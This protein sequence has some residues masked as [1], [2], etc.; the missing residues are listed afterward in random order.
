MHVGT[1]PCTPGSSAREAGTAQLAGE[2]ALGMLCCAVEKAQQ[3]GHQYLSGT[4][5]NVAKALTHAQP[6]LGAHEALS[7]AGYGSS[8]LPRAAS[9]PAGDCPRAYCTQMALCA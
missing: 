8:E 1:S 7:A 2:Q 5:H 4:L 3:G 9:I 6:Q